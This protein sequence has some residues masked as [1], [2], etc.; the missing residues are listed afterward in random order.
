[1]CIVMKC[2]GYDLGRLGMLKL[3][4]WPV[5]QSLQSKLVVLGFTKYMAAHR[6]SSS[7]LIFHD[8]TS[9]FV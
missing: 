8:R 9:G 3:G 6:Q 7:A 5:A 1:M 2:L 4:L